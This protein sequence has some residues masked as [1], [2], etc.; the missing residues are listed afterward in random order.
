METL[1]IVIGAF[2]SILIFLLGYSVN[3]VLTG[4]K[5]LDYVESYLEDTERQVKHLNRDIHLRVD[6]DIE[7]THQTFRDVE[8]DLR[9]QLDSRLDKLTNQIIKMI[10]PT[11][12][13]LMK[14]IE[15]IEEESYRLRMNM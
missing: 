5:R 14:R 1:Y 12:E 10:P 15:K 7:D 13:E 8:I 3:G 11:N 4:K 9:S 6:K 2:S